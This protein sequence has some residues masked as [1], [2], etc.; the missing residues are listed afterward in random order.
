[1]NKWGVF[2]EEPHFRIL[3]ELERDPKVSQRYLAEQLGVSV[4]KI[5]Y[6]LKALIDRGLVKA[7]NFRNSKNK[8]AYL[9]VLT[10]RGVSAKSRNALHFLQRK[11]AEYEALRKEIDRLRREAR[12]R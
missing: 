8:R 9:Y 7:N 12:Q 1:L 10:P 6:C 5:N 3:R 2:T 11:T 4:G